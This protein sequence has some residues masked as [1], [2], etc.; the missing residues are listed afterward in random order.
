M[1]HIRHGA[2]N[3]PKPTI[4]TP[5]KVD[6]VSG[7]SVTEPPGASVTGPSV[8]PLVPLQSSAAPATKVSVKAE[9]FRIYNVACP[10]ASDNIPKKKIIIKIFFIK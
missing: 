7:E 5:I 1:Q 4:L 8:E 2:Q 3:V 10:F 9:L 6:P